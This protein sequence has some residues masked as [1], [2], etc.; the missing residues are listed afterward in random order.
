MR[1]GAGVCPDCLGDVLRLPAP[2]GIETLDTGEFQVAS[3]PDGDRFLVLPHRVPTQP[4]GTDPHPPTCLRRHRCP[5]PTERVRCADVESVR[6]P[7]RSDF[8]ALHRFSTQVELYRAQALGR[9]RRHAGQRVYSPVAIPRGIAEL[10]RLDPKHCVLCRCGLDADE[11][12]EIGS[13]DGEPGSLL[14]CSP[15][16]SAPPYAD[17]D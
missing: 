12:I 5:G 15:S 1:V 16:C 14:A 7:S 8:T 2:D 17:L 9:L 10:G 13:I 3:V 11:A 4:D 6:L